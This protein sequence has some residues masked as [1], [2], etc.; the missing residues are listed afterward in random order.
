[1]VICD[2]TYSLYMQL[3][4]VVAF[5][6]K[7]IWWW[8]SRFCTVIM[9]FKF[10]TFPHSVDTLHTV[11][12]NILLFCSH[13]FCLIIFCCFSVTYNQGFSSLPREF[14]CDFVTGTSACCQNRLWSSD[15]LGSLCGSE[16]LRS[17][18]H[19]LMVIVE[20]Y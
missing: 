5:S 20:E 10:Y 6:F 1:M 3:K 17:A 12:L 15:V 13:S 8:L 4:D 18:D 9:P 11:L 14:S 2:A 7:L 19:T 16:P